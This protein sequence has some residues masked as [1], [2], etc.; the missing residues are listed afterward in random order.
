MEG[1]KIVHNYDSGA[2]VN[3]VLI[4][5]AQ[6]EETNLNCRNLRVIIIFKKNIRFVFE[7]LIFWNSLPNSVVDADSVNT[8]RSR[9][10]RPKHC[11]NQDVVM[12]ALW[13]RETIYIFML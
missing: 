8:F 12:V 4:I 7:S 2:A 13:N 9:L 5:L 10:D 1:Y 11:T 3:L 6:L